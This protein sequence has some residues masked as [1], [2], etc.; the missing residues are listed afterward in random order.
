MTTGTSERNAAGWTC[1]GQWQ[2]LFRDDSRW[3]VYVDDR[4]REDES[5][6]RRMAERQQAN[7]VTQWASVRPVDLLECITSTCINYLPAHLA[8]FRRDAATRRD[9]THMVMLASAAAQFVRREPL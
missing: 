2:G 4:G 8:C 6:R 5:V 7:E 3:Q 1:D 9:S